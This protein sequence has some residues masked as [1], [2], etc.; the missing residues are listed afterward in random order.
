[1]SHRNGAIIHVERGYRIAEVLDD[2]AAGHSRFIGYCVLGPGA[3]EARVFATED[4]AMATLAHLLREA[5][6]RS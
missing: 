4:E 6:P 2:G 5:R 3:E 1:M